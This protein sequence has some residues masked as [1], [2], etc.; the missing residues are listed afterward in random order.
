[1]LNDL[2]QLSFCPSHAREDAMLGGSCSIRGIRFDE[3][4]TD[5]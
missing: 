4:K 1:M 3:V 2:A 5:K